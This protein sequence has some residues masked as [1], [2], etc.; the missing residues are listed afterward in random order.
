MGE[1]P[2]KIR[3]DIEATRSRLT[4]ELGLLS[5]KIS[6]GRVAGRTA[7]DARSAVVHARERVAS[8]AAGARTRFAGV[9]EEL[10]P[11]ASATAHKASVTA[12]KAKQTAD[13]VVYRASQN[14]Q[15][16]ATSRKVRES[17]G[18][19]V[20]TTRRRATDN[21]GATRAVVTGVVGTAVTIAAVTVI[22]RRRRCRSW[23]E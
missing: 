20:R 19:A 6:P 12:H 3:T 2:D 11:K 1:N 9:T 16:I 21:P 10:A 17:T 8:G 14:P 5:E 13:E 18:Q 4:E 22:V 7:A 15:V 23:G